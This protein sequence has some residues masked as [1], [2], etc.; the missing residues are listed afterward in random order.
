M[1]AIQGILTSFG[2][3]GSALVALG[4]IFLGT[5]AVTRWLALGKTSFI[6]G[7]RDERTSGR[8]E[9]AEKLKGQLETINVE[10]RQ[11]LFKA[12]TEANARFTALQLKANEEQRKVIGQ[13]RDQALEQM[14]VVR[15][16]V[17]KQVQSEIG[18]I[19]SEIPVLARKIV[20]QLLGTGG[21]N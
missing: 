21:R 7:E 3:S 17:A 1:D 2:I 6:V 9:E 14:K 4:L 10:V 13:A 19:Q 16:D 5:Y 11:G 12:R 18:K 15:A 20:D 8:E